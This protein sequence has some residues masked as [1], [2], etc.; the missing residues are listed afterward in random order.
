MYRTRPE[1]FA[2]SKR[3]NTDEILQA[4]GDDW[5]KDR[6][7]AMREEIRQLHAALDHG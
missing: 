7:K 5:R 1:L 6:D 3:L 4:M 2:N